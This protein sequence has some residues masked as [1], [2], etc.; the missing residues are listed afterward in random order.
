MTINAA[1][2]NRTTDGIS[3]SFAIETDKATVQVEAD[4]VMNGARIEIE[5]CSANTAGKFTSAGEDAVIKNPGVRVVTAPS[6]YFIRLRQAGSVSGTSI[7]ATI[8]T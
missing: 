5:L 1:F 7:N 6:G 4:S 2:T 8:T 3:S